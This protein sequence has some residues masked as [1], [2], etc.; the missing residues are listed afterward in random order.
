[1]ISQY[2]QYTRGYLDEETAE[3]IVRVAAANLPFWEDLGVVLVD[4]EFSEA[5]LRAA[6]EE[7]P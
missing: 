7:G 5:V 6:G 3:R 2:I 1:M 4:S